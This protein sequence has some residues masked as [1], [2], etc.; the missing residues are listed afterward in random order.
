LNRWYDAR[1]YHADVA[2]HGRYPL[3]G[4]LFEEFAGDE[5]FEREHDAV[6]APDANG[7][8]AVLDRFYGILDLEVAAI[9]GED[10]VGEIVACAYR[11]LCA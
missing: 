11:R 10:G 2:V 9:G 1:A 6:L 4:V 3:V 8:A 5:L 7:C